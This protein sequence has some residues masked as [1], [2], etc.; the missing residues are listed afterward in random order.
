MRY[1]ILSIAL[2]LPAAAQTTVLKSPRAARAAP[3]A[4]RN[5]KDPG[6]A[7]AS[8]V[9]GFLKH[10]DF[11]HHVEFLNK[12]FPEDVVNA[13]PD[14]RAWEWMERNVPLFTCPDADVERTWYYRWWTFRKHIKQTPAGYILTEFLRP[15]KHASD[16]N[17]I[18]CALGH[19]IAEGRW[20]RDHQ[21]IDQHVSFWLRGGQGGGLQRAY[22]QYS[23]W[24]AWAAYERWLADG[25]TAW[26]T[27]LLDPLVLDYRK[28]EEERLL[29]SGLFWQY[30]VRDGMEE[31]AS[32][33]RKNKNARPSINSYMY[34][35]ANAIAAIA[36]M[37]GKQD[38]VREYEDKAARL[39]TLVEQQLWD[40]DAVFFKALLD[41]GKLAT[42]REEIGFT[43]WLF[44]L[45]EPNRGYEQAWKQLMDPQG[46]Y[47]PYG[48]TTAEQRHPA[49]GIFD[50][51]DNCQWN[52]PSWPFSTAITLK[53]LANVLNDYP[54]PVLTASDYWKTFLIYTRSHKFRRDDGTVIPFI[55]EDLHPQTGE[56]WARAMQI[57]KKT[58]RARGDHYNHSS[59]NDLIVTGVAGLRPRADDRVVVNPLVPPGTWDWFC[60]DG[61]P[62]HGRSLT[63]LW[64][65]TGQKFGKGK[66][67]R[68]LADGREIARAAGLRRVS[69]KLP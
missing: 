26:L 60:L 33:S 69:G 55:D 66:G 2:L 63:I 5:S 28:W 39:R 36:R 41:T 20:V 38:L 44:N 4:G 29:P 65:R 56:W 43:P 6:A 52:G 53:A 22:H 19:H 59:Y 14:A 30:D 50:V 34:A 67:L 62:Y 7:S 23:Q 24:T 49:Y 12:T 27:S 32:G 31:S 25:N 18:S 1:L 57:K 15:V 13:I 54:R 11:R 8:V 21:Y 47:A 48:P 35:N 45:P 9:G 61:I 40:G 51:G 64:D 68:V 58:F 16:Y 42:V 10:G 46:F 37:A 3:N 17:A